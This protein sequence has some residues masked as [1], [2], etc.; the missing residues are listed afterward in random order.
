MNRK[1]S[2]N[3]RQI[4]IH[5]LWALPKSNIG[6]LAAQK[7]FYKLLTVIGNFDVSVSTSDK[8]T[9]KRY[10]PEVK[11]EAIYDLLQPHIGSKLSYTNALWVIFTLLNLPLFTFMALFTKMRINMPSK[12][13]TI[14]RMKY[15]DVFVDLNLELLKGFP[16]SVSPN[17]LRQ[18][19]RIIIIHKIF[20]SFRMLYS[21]WVDVVI[22]GLFK[23]RLIL[24]PA[25]FGPF[26]NLP[27]ITQ[28]TVRF[29]LNRFIDLIL[30]REPYSAKLLDR[31]GVKN[32]LLVTD[33]ALLIQGESSIANPKIS[34]NFTIGFAPAMLTNTLTTREIDNYVI[35][36]ARC[37]DK[38]NDD[39][40]VNVVFLPSSSDDVAMC[41]KI[42][43]KIHNKV[44]KMIITDDVDEYELC[45]RKL[46]LL[47]TTRMH[48]SIIAA[49]N[50]IPF[51]TI[52]YD[53][54][55]IGVL[56]QLGLQTFSIHIGKISTQNL[57]DKIR[58]SFQNRL[59]IKEKLESVLPNLQAETTDK[60]IS[61]LSSHMEKMG[62]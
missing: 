26:E 16:I 60:L 23:K 29:I 57:E 36:H 61:V 32:Y 40:Q 22:K 56:Q 43:S 4:R 47:V 21:L 5:I 28:R 54:K 20:W 34:S 30:V 12:I 35:A 51:L 50:F 41:K 18:K 24:G 62:N 49:R 14:N 25:S 1:G 2:S 17:L 44:P 15:C 58:D 42:A 27:T 39:C 45:I 8:G 55:Q 53:H 48:P 52:I 31:L 9:F 37:I 7:A 3:N 33:A 6:T 10:H 59:Q 11:N 13:E 38:L 46:S 19:S